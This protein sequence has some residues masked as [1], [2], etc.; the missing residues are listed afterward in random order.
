MQ[1]TS[2]NIFLQKN[3]IICKIKL[4]FIAKNFNI[5]ALISTNGDRELPTETA[6]AH[7]SLAVV[8]FVC[9]VLILVGNSFTIVSILQFTRRKNTYTLLIVSLSFTEVFN[10]LGPN[11]I[12]LY[13]ILDKSRELK[14]LFTLC[15]VQAWLMVFFRIVATIL[16]FVLTLDRVFVTTLPQFYHKHW[17]GKLFIIIFFG[18]WIS[19]TFL[20]TWPL[21]WLEGFQVSSDSGG[22]FCLFPHDSPFAQFFVL[23][24][25]FLLVISC[26][27]FYAIFGMAGKKS[28]DTKNAKHENMDISS[29]QLIAE[30]D[31]FAS[32][33][34][35]SRLVVL[36]AVVY[37]CSLLPWMV[38]IGK[39]C[40]PF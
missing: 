14:D 6:E 35:F 40:F 31:I 3:W 33:K 11:G 34:E 28:F 39:I 5:M 15:R 7:I 10:V 9:S 8:L 36:V 37:F 32:S 17:K 24:H 27:C 19:A 26:F 16:V 20:A 1:T 18:I 12:A 13:A 22:L 25:C 2:A 21:L 38:S 29:R 23:L 4:T 30:K